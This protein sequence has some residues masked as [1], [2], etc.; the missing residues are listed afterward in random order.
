MQRQGDRGRERV[1]HAAQRRALLADVGEEDLPDGAVLIH[2]RGDVALVPADR[3]LVGDRLALARHPPPLGSNL[4]EGVLHR[5]VDL[6]LHVDRRRRLVL[7]V[8]AQRLGGLRPVAVDGERLHP[9]LPRLQVGV[10]DVLRGGRAGHVHGLRDRAR[11][12]RLDRAHHRDV[13]HVGDRPLADGDV[14]HRQVLGLE[15]RGADDRPLLVDVRDDLLDV[16]VGVA[17]RLQRERHRLVDD[18]HLPTTDQLL[19]LHQREVGLHAGR[20]AI[21]QEADRVVAH[22]SVGHVG[23]VVGHREIERGLVLEQL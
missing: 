17:E 16:L 5:L 14:E 4:R 13:T 19:E 9:E 22:E 10:G 23:D 1:H 18:R 6:R 2:A 3:E 21:H 15:A 11:E 12:E 7:S 20:V 8:G